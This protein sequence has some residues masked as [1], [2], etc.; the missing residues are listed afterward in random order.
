MV[1][2]DEDLVELL[3]N[4]LCLI[5]ADGFTWLCF[6]LSSEDDVGLV[7]SALLKA[8]CKLY[9]LKEGEENVGSRV[10]GH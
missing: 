5:Y 9:Q 4:H 10:S 3:D 6:R 1:R 2:I 8:Y 7:G